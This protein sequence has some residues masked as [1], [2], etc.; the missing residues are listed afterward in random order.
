MEDERVGNQ[1][2]SQVL[3]LLSAAAEQGYL[4]PEEYEQRWT[5]GSTAKTVSVLRRQIADLPAQFRWDPYP[6]GKQP[7]GSEA[8]E[9]STGEE[10]ERVGHQQRGQVLERLSAAAGQGYVMPEEYEE[11]SA[12]A[13]TAKTVSVLLAQVADLPV[14]FQWDPYPDRKKP[15]KRERNE[16]PTAKEI[17]RYALLTLVLG[18]LSV[19]L[20]FCYLGWISGIGAI[21][22]SRKSGGRS[23]ANTGRVFGSIGI[24]LTVIVVI[25]RHVAN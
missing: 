3:E 17:E 12:A 21:V 22:A 11:R 6:P 1:Q 10:D 2:R 18:I 9:P 8:I 15:R 23:E 19:P 24:I 7:R 20:A 14:Q 13:S 4:M 25:V 16:P 5:A